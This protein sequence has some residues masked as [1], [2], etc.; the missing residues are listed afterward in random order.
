MEYLLYDSSKAPSR[1]LYDHA[2]G[3]AAD[4]AKAIINIVGARDLIKVR[5]Y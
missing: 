1:P 5:F 2:E 4:A 3:S